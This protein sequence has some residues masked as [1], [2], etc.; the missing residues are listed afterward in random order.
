MPIYRDKDRGCFVYEFDRRIDGQ[1]VRATKRLPRTWNQAQADAFD[2]KESARLYAVA[3]GTGGANYL[4]E[5]AVALYVIHRLPQLKHG[6]NVAG[7][8]NEIQHFYVGRPLSALADV[9]KAIQLR[10]TGRNGKPLAPATVKNRIAY[11]RAAV[12][13]A[14]K[15][16]GYGGEAKPT[17]RMTVPE[18]HN[19]SQVFVSRE[20]LIAI[21]RK[22]TDRRSRANVVRLYYTG[23]RFAELS[24]A[25]VNEDRTAYYIADTKNAKPDWQPIHPKARAAFKVPPHPYYS[26]RYHFLKACKALGLKKTIH[27]LRH[28]TAT[29]ILTGGGDLKDVQVALNHKSAQSAMRYS[30][31]VQEIKVKALSYIGKR[32]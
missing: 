11:L 7:E 2:R 19:T 15:H 10:P 3:T 18:V 26:V 25:V 24:R 16:H 6:K 1:R 32:A 14:W 28:G 20:E 9:S 27:K 30:H 4:I 22:M 5:N 13:Y 12:N 21:L 29:A 8:L 31:F 17:E 23:K